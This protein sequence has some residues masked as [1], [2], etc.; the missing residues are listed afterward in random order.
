MYTWF[1]VSISLFRYYVIYKASLIDFVGKIHQFVTN[2]AFT[3]MIGKMSRKIQ[4]SYH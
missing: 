2:D 3:R 4:P 1:Q